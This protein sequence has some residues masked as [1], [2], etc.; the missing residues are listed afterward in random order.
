M[1]PLA[2]VQPGR[3]ER[4]RLEVEGD[5]TV[6]QHG[7]PPVRRCD[8]DHGAGGALADGPAHLDASTFEVT[9]EELPH[10]VYGAA[11]QKSCGTAQ[12]DSPRGNVRGL[13]ARAH[14]GFAVRIR[15][16]FDRP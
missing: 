10:R 4:V 14:A 2:T 9:R 7:A 1:E 12:S 11:R 13:A 5:A 15:V 3:I 6:G 16:L 8:R